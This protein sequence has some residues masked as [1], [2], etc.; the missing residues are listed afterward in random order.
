MT[1]LPVAS[2]VAPK[3]APDASE[4]LGRMLELAP[5]AETLL[6]EDASA[7]RAALECDGVFVALD[8]GTYVELPSYR[9]LSPEYDPRAL[10]W[11]VAVKRS[12][13]PIWRTTSLASDPS[14]RELGLLV[15][16]LMEDE[17][18]G[19]LGA[20]FPY[21]QLVSY[22]GLPREPK[23]LC[24][25]LLDASGARIATK[26]VA[27]SGAAC[28]V[29]GSLRGAA[30]K[31]RDYGMVEGSDRLWLFDRLERTG[32]YYIAEFPRSILSED[33]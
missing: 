29:P 24:G 33:P 10:D 30:E 1:S 17:V 22:L 26:R 5:L 11:Y 19:V 6:G 4:T 7:S 32:W 2:A 23:L 13:R 18:I 8:K 27:S 21:E 16:L 12:K 28:A 9:A 15:P 20:L 3:H 31:Q 14:Y 25:T